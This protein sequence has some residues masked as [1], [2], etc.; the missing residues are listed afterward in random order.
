MT[1]GK[2][3]EFLPSLL[4]LPALVIGV[5]A[6]LVLLPM[7][8]LGSPSGHDF[9]FHMNSWMEVL[10]QWKQGIVYPRWAAQA[11][12]GCGEARF[13]FYPPFSWVLGALLA[14]V[15]P[16]YL[17]PGAFIWIALTAAGCSMFFLAR[18]WMTRHHAIF[19]AAFYAANPYHFVIVYW[20][21]AFAELLVAWLLPLLLLLMLRA[22][23]GNR[24]I[25]VFLSL[26]VAAAW[27]TDAPAAVIVNYSLALI[28]V[29]VAIARRSTRPVTYGAA[30]VILGAALAC[31]YL[32]P[33]AYEEKWVNIAEVL[34]PGVRPQDNFLF[35]VI[36]DA[37]HTRFNYLVS[38]VA[39]AE[40]LL[41]VVA[42]FLSRKSRGTN[43]EFWWSLAGWS[44]AAMLLMCSCTFL[45]WEHL[46]KLRFVQ[47]P[48]R[49]L[50]CLNVAFTMFVALGTR[51]VATRVLICLTLAGVLIAVWQRIQAPWWDSANDIA[52]LTADG[53]EGADEYV[54]SGA[55]A[56]EIK[57]DPPRIVWLGAGAVKIHE[58]LWAPES[59]HFT[60][61]VNQPGTLVLR[62]FNY[63]AWKTTV[64]GHPVSTQTT[65]ETGQM[66]VP[67]RPGANDVTIN[68]VRTWDRL[69]GEAI[70][71]LA[72]AVAIGL[73][74][75][76]RRKLRAGSDN[77][78]RRS[79]RDFCKLFGEA[80]SSSR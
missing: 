51:R 48:W 30:A 58:Q 36:N 66:V 29:S 23:T 3:G 56:Y 34:S 19:A 50:L 40:I 75:A 52:E 26:V 35:T 69:C 49:W 45:L 10:S 2:S 32:L 62:L 28:A 63:P 74:W 17:V 27:L 73:I 47:L 7:F 80:W 61:T 44:A 13:F 71:A 15:L 9:E 78:S 64:N 1:S 65:E 76:E 54:P 18:P 67:I 16:W 21:S 72:V 4:P 24:T 5:T 43:P 12:H 11:H 38:T 46:P 77:T 37:D 60:V 20:R 68:L 39:T 79:R 22:T 59:K 14:A 25:I 6:L 70:T 53:Y 42:A 33:A 41:L 31:F 55:D 8:F 57:K